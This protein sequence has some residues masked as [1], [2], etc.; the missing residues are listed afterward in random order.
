MRRVPQ[1][2]GRERSSR[3]VLCAA[4]LLVTMA[5]SSGLPD[6]NP[7]PPIDLGTGPARIDATAFTTRWP[8]KHVVFIIKENRTF[9]NL[10]GRFPGADGATT[11]LDQ[12]SERPLTQALDRIP[13]DIVH[14]YECALQ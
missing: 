2:P 13:V 10:F 5:C 6:W 12:S 8:I 11:G 14:C 7:L 1:R 3:R 4:L 9:D